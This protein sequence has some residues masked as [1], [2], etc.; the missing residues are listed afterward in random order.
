MAHAAF[1][2][3]LR[4]LRRLHDRSIE[5]S[6]GELL[7]QHLSGNESAFDALLRRHAP[8]VW[9]VCRRLLDNEQDAEDAFQAVFLVLLRKAESLRVP[10][11]LAAF[12]HGVASRIAQK[13]RATAQ[14]RRCH[15]SRAETPRPSDPFAVVQQREL[16][17]LLDEELDRL[18]EKYRAPLVLCYLEGLSY[19]EAARQLGWRDGT[20]CGRLARARELLRQRLS[21]RGLTLSGAALAATL[22]EPAPAATVATVSRM[23]VLFTLGETITGSISTP[24]ATLAQS[25]LQ[26]MT[27]AKLKTM[28]VLVAIFCLVAGGGGLAA[29]RIWTAKESPPQRTETPPAIAQRG[30][31]ARKESLARTDRYGDSLPPGAIARLGTMRLRRG[32]I[33]YALP[34]RDAFLSVLERDDSIQVCKWRMSTG[35][36]LFDRQYHLSR[37]ASNAVV[38]SDGK[39]LA[40]HGF[41]PKRV[42]L[43]RFW[44]LSSGKALSEIE[45]PSYYVR[46]LAFSPD[47]TTLAA[48]GEAPN[49]LRL[50]DIKSK[51][52]LR[53]SNEAKD[54][55]E[56]LTFSPDGKTLAST[57]HSMRTILLWDTSTLQELHVLDDEPGAGPRCIAFSP[58]S[59]TVATALRDGK[60][61]TIR[62]WDVATGKEVRQFHSTFGTGALAFSPD[63]KILAAGGTLAIGNISRDIENLRPIHLWELSS[64]REVHRLPGHVNWVHSLVFSLDC[65][66][67][68]SAGGSVMK[69]W[70]VG[71]GKEVVPLAEHEGWINSVAFSPGGRHLATSSLDGTIRMWEPATGKLVRIFEGGVR[72]RVLHI[73]FSPDGR[74][75]IS[76][77]PDGSLRFWDV[78]TGRQIRRLLVGQEGYPCLFAYSPDGR[79]LAVRNKDG[80]VG[81][82]DAATGAE[83]RRLSGGMSFG[84]ALCFSPDSGKLA[85]MSFGSRD[86][87]Q[88][89]QVWDVATGAEKFK[90]KFVY[91]TPLVFSPDSKTLF[92]LL[93]EEGTERS[94]SLRLWDFD[95][96]QDRTYKIDPP[97]MP[98]SLTVSPDGR[99]LAWADFEGTITLWDLAANQVRRRFKEHSLRIPSLAFSP[100]GKTL[101]SG[102]E[103]TTVLIWDV[104]G[105]PMTRHFVAPSPERLPSLWDDLASKDAAKAFDAI[106]LLTATPEQAVPLL[107][108]KLKPATVRADSKQIGRLIGD[109][110]S[111]RFEVRQKAM[112]ELGQLGEHAEPA[113][114]AALAAKPPL[115]ARKRIDELLERI[116]AFSATPERLRELRTVEILE[117]IGTSD[118]RQVLRTFVEG[119]P[120][121]RL[122]REAKAALQRLISR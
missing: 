62:L 17:A 97:E 114:R 94:L 45:K 61:K 16:R 40:A 64:G 112:E 2:S 24:V 103:D 117:R 104:T 107:K 33:V 10:Q 67:L 78:A 42:P 91:A 1:G 57:G 35:E 46:A 39:V 120:A 88:V 44:D 87:G 6:D 116:R 81:L 25:A 77:R 84:R 118:A 92:G 27:V 5:A 111:E 13:A 38:S 54:R 69:V 108:A 98:E 110:D 41:G 115:E 18:P 36:L 65:K 50:W 7:L 4:Y 63:G 26:A 79:T 86:S 29:H 80:T 100:D 95:G 82:L 3:L 31:A 70:D 52:E 56:S 105:R 68:V 22:S 109:L 122:T 53:H 20:V 58:D 121:A 85:S 23:A 66:R 47:G 73:A 51:T 43:I 76:D 99:M 96:G 106:G 89:L 37:G 72:P 30:G 15:E 28:G 9:G 49:T 34:E 14:R 74:T 90:R 75:L 93:P 60:S 102:G 119:S 8:M 59:K 55:F 83:K 48:A 32:R 12:L 113:L 71:T 19:T 101:A 11:S 21:R